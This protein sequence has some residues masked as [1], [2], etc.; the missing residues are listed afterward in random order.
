M[1]L[2]GS[3]R[4]AA[5]CFVVAKPLYPH[6]ACGNAFAGNP[7]AFRLRGVGSILADR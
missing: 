1:E 4:K 5:I 6:A 2:E 3:H 7:G